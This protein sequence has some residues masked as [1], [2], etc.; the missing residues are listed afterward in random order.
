MDPG[1]GLESVDVAVWQADPDGSRG[2]GVIGPDIEEYVGLQPLA[3]IK[4]K[5]LQPEIACQALLLIG[6]DADRGRW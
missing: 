2:A 5:R 3:D 6:R 1:V 4:K